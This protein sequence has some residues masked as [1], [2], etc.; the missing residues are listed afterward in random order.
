VNSNVRPHRIHLLRTFGIAASTIAL[1]GCTSAILAVGTPEEEIITSGT[2]TSELQGRLGEP[3][4]LADLSPPLRAWDIP[5]Q[6]Q[7]V[8]L[9]VRPKVT[10]QADG[11]YLQELPENVA[12]QE[13]DYR[14]IGR[15]KR[16]HNTG[17]SV[18]LALMTFGVSEI[19]LA[20]AAAAAKANEQLYVLTVWVG[21]NG[22]ALAYRWTLAQPQREPTR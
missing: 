8:S 11:K 15:L 17:E 19:L 3:I 20:P 18:S 7:R 9:L 4:R 5:K 22:D 10:R 14:F 13:R 6:C 2:T 16:K 12:V 21:A 1:V